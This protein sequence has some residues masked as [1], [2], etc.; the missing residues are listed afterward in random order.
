MKSRSVLGFTLLALICLSLAFL[1]GF[2]TH[3]LLNPGS[4]ELPVL[5]QALDILQNNALHPLPPPPTLEYGMIRGMLEA[6]GDP[7]TIFVEP[8]RHE[9]LSNELQGS[10]GGIGVRLDR[11]PAGALLLYP[12][13]GSPAHKAGIRDADQLVAV[14]N[15]YIK[16]QTMME[17]IQS[18]IRGPVGSEVVIS[19]SRGDPPETLK[20]SLHREPVSLPSVTW[21]L[22][23]EEP[24]IGLIEINILAASTVDEV[25][26][27]VQDLQN[28]G[29]ERFILDLRDNNGGL[30][31]AG[32]ETARLFLA[33]GP[34]LQEQ[35][36]NRP[37]ET[38]A[39]RSRGPFVTLPLAVLINGNTAS[40]AEIV[41][42]ALQRNGRA[43]L[44]G[45]ASYGKDSVQLVFELQDGSSLHVTAARWWIPDLNESGGG[46]Q[47]DIEV[48][49]TETAADAAVRAA[50]TF[51][52]NTP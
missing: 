13:R 47:P 1:S 51:L 8:A 11:N 50:I 41:A 48:N 29:A 45:A 9:L 39:A 49:E 6:Y 21:H 10:F 46:L 40:A 2:L 31:E 3:A 17:E 42:G 4:P 43:P 25:R 34:I 38:F 23:P 20:F 14:D 44:I 32:I 28:R 52:L 19:V 27:A 5:R 30:L 36:R 15:L 37:I 12:F 35:Y 7:N 33:P 22:A 24:S 26:E 16:P 18:A